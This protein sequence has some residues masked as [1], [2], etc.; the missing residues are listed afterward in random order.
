MENVEKIIKRIESDTQ[1]EID[2]VDAAAKA[3]CDDLAA[4]YDEKA[5]VQYTLL[6]EDGKK[7]CEARTARIQSTAQMEAKKSIL[8]FKQ[9]MVSKAFDLALQKLAGLEGERYIK[10]LVAQ[11]VSAAKYGTEELVFNAKDKAAYGADVA[12]EANAALSAKAVKGALTVAGETREISGGLIV[13]QG[14]IETNCTTAS[15][16]QL[17]RNELASQVAEIL[18]SCTEN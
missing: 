11:A 13:K 4:Q 9:E 6:I 12:R 7:Q 17:Y 2:A 8:A 16:V 15:L 10:F 3:K 1:L 14:D 5:N 18:F